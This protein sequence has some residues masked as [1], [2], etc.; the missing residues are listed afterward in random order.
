MFVSYIVGDDCTVQTTRTPGV[1]RDFMEEVGS[2]RVFQHLDRIWNGTAEAWHTGLG[3]GRG[4]AAE[5]ATWKRALLAPA[6]E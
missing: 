2:Y 4:T 1:E 6:G 5:V 3:R